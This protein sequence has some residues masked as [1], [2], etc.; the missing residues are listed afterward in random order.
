[1]TMRIGRAALVIC[2]VTSEA[3]LA[4]TVTPALPPGATK[5]RLIE[6]SIAAYTAKHGKGSCPCDY[7]VADDGTECGQRS[8]NFKTRGRYPLCHAKD[9]TPE[10]EK[11]EVE[12]VLKELLEQANPK[13]K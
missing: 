1:M 3:A 13:P 2:V 8:A 12:K 7:S 11:F 9:V 4:L 6:E 5:R 10:V